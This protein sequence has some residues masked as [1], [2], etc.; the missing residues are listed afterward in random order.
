M[1]SS[2]DGG[3]RTARVTVL[4]ASSR[5]EVLGELIQSMS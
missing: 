3:M 2:Q 4:A 1:E 5:K